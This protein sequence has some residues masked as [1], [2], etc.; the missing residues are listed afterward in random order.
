MY[1]SQTKPQCTILS[2]KIKR[3]SDPSR[4]P[5][6]FGQ[7]PGPQERPCRGATKSLNTAQETIVSFL[8]SKSEV[9]SVAG[10]PLWAPQAA[11]IG[12]VHF[13]LYE[14]VYSSENW[15]KDENSYTATLKICTLSLWHQRCQ[16]QVGFHLIRPPDIVVDGLRFYHGFFLFFA[17]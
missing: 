4:S 13:L 3:K 1:Q 9:V 7:P 11:Q 5:K 10:N 12:P 2:Q 6:I 8:W 14:H 15:Q 17:L 16:N